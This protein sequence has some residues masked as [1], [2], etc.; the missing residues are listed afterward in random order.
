[1]GIIYKYTSPSGKSYIGQT[2][3]SK[4]IREGK[5]GKEYREC[6]VFYNAIQKYG[7]ENFSYEILEECDNSLLDEKEKYYIKKYDTFNNGY[8]LTEGGQDGRTWSKK[9]YQFSQKGNLIKEYDSIT[10]AAY[11]N[12]VNISSLSQVCNGKKYTLLGYLWSYENKCP[13]IKKNRRNKIVYQFNEQGELIREFETAKNA[14]N[15]YKIPIWGIQQCAAKHNRKR[16]IGTIFTY[17]PFVDWE[18]YTLKHKPNH[19]STTIPYG[20][21]EKSF[22]VLCST[23]VDEDI[24]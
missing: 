19:N 22:E 6:P 10:Q 9:V 2:I 11:E 7:I 21:K 14:A 12:K 8:N 15:F 23:K 1:M 17:E 16:V 20:S 18:Y 3:Y 4:K 24:V 13:E 5:D